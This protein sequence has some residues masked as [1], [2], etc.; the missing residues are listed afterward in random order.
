MGPLPTHHGYTSS[1]VLCLSLGCELLGPGLPLVHKPGVEVNGRV[2]SLAERSG[3]RFCV[4]AASGAC[5]MQKAFAPWVSCPPAG[6]QMLTCLL[7][8]QGK[9]RCVIPSLIFCT[10]NWKCHV[11]PKCHYC[12]FLY[13]Y[14]RARGAAAASGSSTPCPFSGIAAS[15]CEDGFADAGYTLL[16]AQETPTHGVA[17]GEKGEEGGQA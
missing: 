17:M 6:M 12:G 15:H 5:G 7:P 14:N 3:H 1:T 10:E 4:G 9:G 16:L 11:N 2:N 8:P 13:Y